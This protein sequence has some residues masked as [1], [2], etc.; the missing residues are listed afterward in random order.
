MDA[1]I[2][3]EVIYC[4][5]SSFVFFFFPFSVL[6]QNSFGAHDFL[7]P[8]CVLVWHPWFIMLFLKLH[9]SLILFFVQPCLTCLLTCLSVCLS[10]RVRVQG[11]PVHP[12]RGHG[13]RFLHVLQSRPPAERGRRRA[14]RQVLQTPA[15][16]LGPL[17][18]EEHR[19]G[20]AEELTAGGISLP[21]KPKQTTVVLQCNN[22]IIK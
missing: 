9:F 6:K 13:G 18:G 11:G 16:P 20:L 17:T 7:A 10:V 22:M 15:G 3:Y 1:C 21:A 14:G 12:G 8:L 5:A 2:Q 4:I 19:T